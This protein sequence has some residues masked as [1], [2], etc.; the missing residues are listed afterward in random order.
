LRLIAGASADIRQ[1]RS[2]RTSRSVLVSGRPSC[3]L[4]SH[5][6]ILPKSGRCALAYLFAGLYVQSVAV[7]VNSVVRSGSRA[8]LNADS[9]RRTDRAIAL[10][11][12]FISPSYVLVGLTAH[13][14]GRAERNG[15][16]EPVPLR[17]SL[18]FCEPGGFQVQAALQPP[19]GGRTDGAG[20]EE[21]GQLGVLCGDEIAPQFALS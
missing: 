12:A 4:P 7:I 3:G 14:V 18:S 19:P 2:G 15:Y 8:A 21:A 20:V 9:A 13:D 11:S 6:P 10:V 5:R 16:A 17:L 1:A